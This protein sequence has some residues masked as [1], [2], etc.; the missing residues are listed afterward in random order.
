MLR[1]LCL[2]RPRILV[3]DVGRFRLKTT[4]S[5]TPPAT[6]TAAATSP[7]FA[8]LATLAVLTA[9]PALPGT[10]TAATAA[11]TFTLTP[12][13]RGSRRSAGGGRRHRSLGGHHVAPRPEVGIHFDDADLRDLRSASSRGR[14]AGATAGPAAEARA[15]HWNAARGR[16]LVAIGRW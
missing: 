14:T 6:S 7:P 1:C 15:A 13:L 2:H 9:G 10:A 4:R 16:R 12:L 8:T 11:T 5:P 3:R